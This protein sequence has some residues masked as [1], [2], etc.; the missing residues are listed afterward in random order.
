MTP[1]PSPTPDTF[2]FQT[3]QPRELLA[4]V[5]F[6]AQ[7]ADLI[8]HEP[9]AWRWLSISLVLGVQ[10]AC[11][12]ALDVGDPEGTRAMRRSDARIVARWTKAGRKTPPPFPVREPRIVSPLEL[13][14][15][16]GDHRFL[17]PPFQLPLTRKMREDFDALVDLRNTFLHFSQ[18]GWTVDLREFPPLVLSACA[19]IRHLAVTQPAYLRNAERGHQGRVSAALDHIAT[20]MEHYL[21]EATS[22]EA[23]A[24]N[25]GNWDPLEEK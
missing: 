13:L 18:D 9:G 23:G 8:D 14:E 20:A 15:R 17:R 21:A 4:C 6:A 19:V 12:C 3:S 1:K 24:E 25:E 7:Q 11:L 2:H 16:V 5:E 22:Q 10:N